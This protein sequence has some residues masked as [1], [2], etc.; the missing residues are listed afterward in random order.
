MNRNT[1]VTD[2]DLVRRYI[3]GDDRAFD[4]LL[5]R[6]GNKVFSQ[7]NYIVKD[8]EVANDLFQETFVKVVVLLR[9]RRYNEE[10]KFQGWLARIANNVVMDYF[11]QKPSAMNYAVSTDDCDIDIL[12]Q[13]DLAEMPVE[14]AIMTRQTEEDA[15]KIMQS[16]PESQREIIEMRFYRDMSFKDIA[17]QTGMSINTAL[18]RMRYAV[19]NMRRIAS[20]YNITFY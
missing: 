17:E 15:V 20:D 13:E 6:Y 9:D 18:G 10:G 16:L 5:S 19:K 1:V 14:H 12:N 8:D 11:R 2:G 3:A 7:I 4:S